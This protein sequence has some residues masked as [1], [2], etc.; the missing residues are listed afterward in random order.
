MSKRRS[1]STKVTR[2][3]SYDRLADR[4]IDSWLESQ[5]NASDAVRAAIRAAMGRQEQARAGKTIDDLYQAIQELRVMVERG[6]LA[7]PGPSDDE[8]PDVALALDNLGV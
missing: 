1:R 8:P 7:A 2:T 6:G 3:F 4:D 5:P